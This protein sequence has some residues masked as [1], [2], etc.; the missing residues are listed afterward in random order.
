MKGEPAKYLGRLVSKEH[1][2]VYIHAPDGSNKLVESWDDFQKHMEIGT[3]FATKEDALASIVIEDPKQKRVRKVKPIEVDEPLK[4]LDACE[5][6][7]IL[8]NE[9][10]MK[11]DFLPKSRK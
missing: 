4:V 11:D 6:D 3:W 2:R 1:F 7:V 5:N 9:Q 10:S 8:E